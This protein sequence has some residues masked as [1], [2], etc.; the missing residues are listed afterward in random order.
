MADHRE[1]LVDAR[2]KKRAEREKQLDKLVK[3][4]MRVGL[5]VGD[6]GR[7]VRFVR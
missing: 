3:Q 6:D 5:V 4:S 1:S 2:R 7:L